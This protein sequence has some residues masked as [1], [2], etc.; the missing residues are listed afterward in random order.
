MNT[1]FVE[2]FLMLARVGSVRRVAEHMHTTPGAISMRV[3]ALEAQ[4][5]VTLFD[6]D[7]K[8]VSITADGRHLIAAAEALVDATQ[9]L[10]R[11]AGSQHAVG[12]RIRVG[13]IE[14]VVYTFLPDLMKAVAARL[15]EVELD[16]T[17]DLT[18][19]LA[20][21]LMRG[22]LDVVFRVAGDADNPFVESE[23]LMEVPAHWIARRGMVPVRNPL[24]KTLRMQLLTQMRG[25]LPHAGAVGIAQQLA[26]QQGLAL[27]AL[28]IT[29]SP[30]L[31][32]LVSLVREGV[33]V[34]IM[35]GVL[36]RDFLERRELVELALP[37]PE[38]YR[39]SVCHPRAVLPSVTRLAEVARTVCRA[40][41]RRID[42]RWVRSIG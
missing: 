40:Y 6:W 12:G 14:T 15:P 23:H 4:L 39:V 35:P 18:S 37:V 41:C 25:S 24:E 42:E 2:T 16:L 9:S 30:S 17:I 19:H 29:G 22:E 5:G 1:R 7:H 38:P 21:Q 28:R 8:T 13:V 27:S 3:R 10:E 11:A 20:E 32:A 36:V 31:A 34:G 26:A 33:G